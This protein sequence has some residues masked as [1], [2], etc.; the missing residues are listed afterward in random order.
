MKTTVSNLRQL[1][2]EEITNFAAVQ[3]RRIM[4]P[5]EVYDKALSI[6]E[7]GPDLDLKIINWLVDYFTNTQTAIDADND[8]SLVGSDGR[9]ALGENFDDTFRTFYSICYQTMNAN[10]RQKDV[11][12]PGE[13][14]DEFFQR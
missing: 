10:A 6:A 5:D 4:T 14:F 12:W 1:I 8:T 13:V 3:N 7:F 9:I 2:R 11:E